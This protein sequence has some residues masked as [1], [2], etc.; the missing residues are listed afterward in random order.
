MTCIIGNNCYKKLDKNLQI[1]EGSWNSRM[2]A[3]AIADCKYTEWK[4][5]CIHITH[6][7]VTLIKKV[8]EYSRE[9]K[10]LMYARDILHRP[11]GIILVNSTKVDRWFFGQSGG[12]GWSLLSEAQSLKTTQMRSSDSSPLRLD[13]SCNGQARGW[14][15]CL[16]AAQR[17]YSLKL[18]IGRHDVEVLCHL[19]IKHLM[20]VQK[21]L[22][23]RLVGGL[24]LAASSQCWQHSA[25]CHVGALPPPGNSC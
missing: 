7:T 16:A 6:W 19:M 9:K 17:L 4:I 23:Y 5:W 24:N 3:N 2:N 15:C 12:E 1:R 8:N 10:G 21:S 20:G 13:G 25:D 11:R 22:L 14:T 18:T